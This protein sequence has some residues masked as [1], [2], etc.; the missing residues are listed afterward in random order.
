MKYPFFFLL[1]TACYAN[2]QDILTFD[3]R[4]VECEDKWV[5]FRESKDG[6]HSFGFIYIDEQAG[7]TFDSEGKFVITQSGEFIPHKDT[8]SL[9]ARLEPNDVLVALIPESKFKELEV[10]PIPDWLKYYKTDTNS[11]SR[12]YKWG[13]MYNGWNQCAKAL[14]Y[15]ER[16]AKLDPQYKGLAVELAFSY[17]CLE[18]YDKAEEILEVEIKASP[19]NAYVN[20]EYIYTLIKNDKIGNA[21]K[22]FKIATENLESDQYNAENCFNIMAYFFSTKDEEK[23]NEWYKLLKKQPNDNNMIDQ[24]ADKMKEAIN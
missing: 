23:F 17:N 10:S 20:K 16:A 9:K 8:I 19:S 14:S 22:Q 13:Y 11:V 1:F 21:E 5:A 4:F 12:L 6:T 2:A 15:L 7:L 3:K 18:Q 24:Y